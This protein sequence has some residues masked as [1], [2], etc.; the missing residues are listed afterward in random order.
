MLMILLV[1]MFVLVFIL[2][3]LFGLLALLARF[4]LL[5]VPLFTFLFH[6][7]VE[8]LGIEFGRLKRF[9]SHPVRQRKFHRFLYVTERDV[10]TAVECRDRLCGSR[11]NDLC[12]VRPDT[13]FDAHLGSGSQEIVADPG[14]RKSR[15][16]IRY[17]L[18]KLPLRI[19]V[20]I[21]E[22]L[23]IGIKLLCNLHDRNTL[24]HVG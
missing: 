18:A 9:L 21:P 23:R 14:V 12:P 4:L 20:T 15:F 22:P 13:K 1:F 24:V 10:G 3:L 19:L 7:A 16:C 2:V 8:F 6:H 11:D 5:F 17:L